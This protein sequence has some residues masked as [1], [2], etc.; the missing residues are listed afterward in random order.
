MHDFVFFT[1]INNLPFVYLS[2]SLISPCPVVGRVDVYVH[3]KVHIHV[4]VHV[5][6]MYMSMSVF[7]FIFMFIFIY[8]RY[9]W[10]RQPVL[11][12]YD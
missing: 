5:Q 2:L 12:N 11:K 1:N 3:V 6:F 7:V 10:P 4:H 9:R 8:L